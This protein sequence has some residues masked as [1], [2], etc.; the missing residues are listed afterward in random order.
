MVVW[1]KGQSSNFSI[2]KQIWHPTAK[3][4]TQLLDAK[5]CWLGFWSNQ[6][7]DV[8]FSWMQQISGWAF[9]C[10]ICFWMVTP[11]PG[12]IIFSSP[13]CRFSTGTG[14]DN[15]KPRRFLENGMLRF[16]SAH[17]IGAWGRPAGL[18][19]IMYP[20]N[21]VTIQKQILYPKAGRAKAQTARSIQQF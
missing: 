9:G 1:V 19:K 3:K 4:N 20:G 10:R 2:Q 17:P 13:G 6:L 11:L 5:K 14:I 18:E 16:L 15:Q 8:I 7:L 12:Y 21:G